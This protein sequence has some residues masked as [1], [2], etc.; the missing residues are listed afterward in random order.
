MEALALGDTT[1]DVRMARAAGCH[2]VGVTWG[3]HTADEIGPDA[4]ALVRDFSGLDAYLAG[5]RGDG[6]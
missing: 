2:G 1:H 5:W 3:F 4:H 6:G